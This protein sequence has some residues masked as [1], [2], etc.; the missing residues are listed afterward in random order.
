MNVMI[1]NSTI[2][3]MTNLL[4]NFSEYRFIYDGRIKDRYDWNIHYKFNNL[5]LEQLESELNFTIKKEKVEIEF[6]HLTYL[7]RSN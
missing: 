4:S 5:T 1:D 7:D 3:E 6:L 2:E